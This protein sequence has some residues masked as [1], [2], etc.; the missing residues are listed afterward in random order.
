M[1]TNAETKRILIDNYT[2]EEL[3]DMLGLTPYD[4]VNDFSCE[5]NDKYD[6]IQQRIAD[7]L[8]WGCDDEE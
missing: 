1:L 7:D 2:V 4:I 5:I 8:G 6:E 3:C